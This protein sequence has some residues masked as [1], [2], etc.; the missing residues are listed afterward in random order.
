[1]Q[2]DVC[3]TMLLPGVSSTACSAMQTKTCNREVV[4]WCLEESKRASIVLPDVSQRFSLSAYTNS[5]ARFQK[6]LFEQQRRH[7]ESWVVLVTSWRYAKHCYEGIFAALVDNGMPLTGNR[8]VSMA[9]DDI[10]CLLIR[11]CLVNG[12]I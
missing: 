9:R 10:S 1:M 5:P 3:Q 11:A 4:V 12:R 2:C 6:W 7:V 8:E